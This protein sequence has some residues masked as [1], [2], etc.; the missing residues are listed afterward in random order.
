MEKTWRFFPTLPFCNTLGDETNV[1]RGGMTGILHGPECRCGVRRRFAWQ[2][3]GFAPGCGINRAP[4]I[5]DA[6]CELVYLV[7][8]LVQGILPFLHWAKLP[9][10][11]PMPQLIAASG[12][13]ATGLAVSARVILSWQ[14]ARRILFFDA[15]FRL[16]TDENPHDSMALQFPLTG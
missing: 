11:G 14:Q 15:A 5:R 10:C 12:L 16:Q 8:R 4:S 3:G 6:G 9:F 1:L 13:P 2:I 7:P